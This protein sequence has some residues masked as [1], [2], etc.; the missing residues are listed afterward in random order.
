MSNFEQI[1]CPI[2]S[3]MA[4]HFL[5]SCTNAR[6]LARSQNHKLQC[7][8][9]PQ[10]NQIAIEAT[11]T[12]A[13]AETRKLLANIEMASVV[14]QGLNIL[15]SPP[16]SSPDMAIITFQGGGEDNVISKVLAEEFL[17]HPDYFFK[18]GT[19]LRKYAALA[20]LSSV[21]QT[22]TIAMVAIFPQSPS[23]TASTW[24]S[25]SGPKAR[26]RRVRFYWV[27]RLQRV[28]QVIC[29]RRKSFT[30]SWTRME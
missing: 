22:R 5:R 9:G 21:L 3:T 17:I 1:T 18:F 28:Q 11:A 4:A 7:K 20:N 16:M 25:S 2:V 29:L 13:Y 24:M 14:K 27:S 10:M 12:E 19:M 15:Y 26:W 6:A 23:D 8:R 30:R